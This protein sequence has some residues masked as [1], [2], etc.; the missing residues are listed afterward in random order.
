MVNRAKLAGLRCF[1]SF[2]D[3]VNIAKIHRQYSWDV[4]GWCTDKKEGIFRSVDPFIEKNKSTLNPYLDP[5]QAGFMVNPNGINVMAVRNYMS[6]LK[7]TLIG[8]ISHSNG[9]W[10]TII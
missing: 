4:H 2:R 5:Q 8:Y 1:K 7:Y 3:I 6:I 9:G 10:R